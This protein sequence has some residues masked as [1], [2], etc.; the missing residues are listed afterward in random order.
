MKTIFDILVRL[1]NKYQG[2]LQDSR[3]V[4]VRNKTCCL[5]L[6]ISCCWLFKRYNLLTFQFEWRTN[7]LR[8]EQSKCNTKKKN[9]EYM[10]PNK[11]RKI[12]QQNQIENDTNFGLLHE[13]IW[14]S[15]LMKAYLFVII[16]MI[17]LQAFIKILCIK[18]LS[19]L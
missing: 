3:N 10:Y 14:S 13:C 5:K 12:K 6:Y 2:K 1:I 17:T 4:Y 11:K 19:Y 15:A 8:T 16:T 7:M 9:N 18:S